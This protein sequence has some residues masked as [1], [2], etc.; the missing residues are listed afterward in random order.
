MGVSIAESRGKCYN[1]YYGSCRLEKTGE[2]LYYENSK[3]IK[4][5]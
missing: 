4:C 3:E 1:V 2:I 5:L